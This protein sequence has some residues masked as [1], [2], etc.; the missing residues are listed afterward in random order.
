MND[1]EGKV[2]L[3]TGGA[4]GIGRETAQQFLDRGASVELWDMD[5]DAGDKLVKKW[6]DEGHKVHFEKVDV[7]DF[8]AVKKAMN[9]LQERWE[10]LD[11]LVNNAGITR[12][13]TLKK[14]SPEEWKQVVDVNLNGVF[15]CGKAA[16]EVMRE[17]ESGVILNASS[18]VGVYGNFGQSNYVATKSG[19][20]GLT[21]TWA[22]ELGRKGVRV[23]AVAPGFIETPMVD[24]VP[25]K[26]LEELKG[27]TPLGRLGKPEDIASAYVFLASEQAAFI[28]GTVLQVDGGLVF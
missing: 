11:I 24:T 2:I 6:T 3:I 21:K 10:Q 14:M 19:V 4:G 7:T 5:K 13:A 27:Q 28:T 25:D 20:I 22:R 16:A 23:N 17:Q 1:F 18:V 26:V 9:N 15:Y 8:E 12:D